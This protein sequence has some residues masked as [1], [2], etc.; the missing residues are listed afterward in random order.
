MNVSILGF[1]AG[2]IG[3]T[4]MNDDEAV[5]VLD[6][7]FNNGITL[8]DTARGY[9]SS[10]ERIGKF[11]KGKREKIVLST[12]VGY[13]IP[14][15][16][17]WTYD[18]IIA[19]I[20]HALNLMHTDYLDVVHLHSCP[21]WILQ[22][23]EVIDAL[24]AMKEKGEIRVAAYSGEN[25]ELQYAIDTNCFGSIQTSVNMFDQRGIDTYCKQAKEKQMGVIGKRP[26]GNCAWIYEAQPVSNYAEDYWKRMKAM[27]LD[28]EKQW[29]EIALRFSAFHGN[30]DSLI[31]GTG[32]SE[33]LLKNIAML[34][35]GP[36]PEETVRAIKESFKTHDDNWVGLI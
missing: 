32:N 21:L 11:L 31:I 34:E 22:K 33:H 6:T 18:I 5:Y 2:H 25:D 20:E 29:H 27:G 19:G 26:L 12:K 10:E 13:S 14:G 36:L 8:F 23:H 7:A 15:Y 1:G 30:A 28:Y 24:L 3:G 17:D 4:N 35:Q 9:G 16:D